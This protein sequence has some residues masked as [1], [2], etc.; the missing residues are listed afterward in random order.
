LASDAPI[1][2]VGSGLTMVDMTLSLNRRGYRGP[3]AVVSRRGLLSAAHRPVRES[4][5]S[6]RDVP[7]GAELSALLAWMRG[8]A[9]KAGAEGADWRSAVDALRRLRNVCGVL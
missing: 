9:T 2:I 4:Y 3:I 6:E 7:F 8:L 5:L 1:L